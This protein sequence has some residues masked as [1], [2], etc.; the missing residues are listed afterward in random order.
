MLESYYPVVGGM[1]AQGRTL[2]LALKKQ[3]V[4]PFIITRKTGAELKCDEEVDGIPVHRC[5][6]SGAGSRNRWFF[7]FT[8][9]PALIRFRHR[10]D[11][12][13]VSGFRVL[14]IS[15]VLIGKLFG[16][17]TVLKAECMGE[18]NGAFFTGGL[19]LLRLKQGFLGMRLFLAIRNRWLK[20]GDAFVSMY[21]EMTEEFLACGVKASAIYTI[22]NAVDPVGFAPPSAETKQALFLELGL[23]GA[24]RYMVYT[25]RL[26]SYKGVM[27]LLRVWDAIRKN[28][29]DVVLLM[30]GAGGVDV[31]NCEEEA[32]Q[33]AA[34]HE[35]G[36]QVVFTGAVR[37]VDAWLK[38]C[39]LFILPTEN[40][41]FP[42]CIL[43]AMSTALAIIAT[44]TGALKDVIRDGE[45]GRIIPVGCDE[46][47]R[48]AMDELL[49]NAGERRRLGEAAR[50][51][52]LAHYTPDAV[53]SRYMELF[54]AVGK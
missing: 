7:L 2:A 32:R 33:Y 40:D 34:A 20:L 35:M 17:T 36:E 53:V 39:D 46:S 22:P 47:L 1:E 14:G 25:G 16:K 50:K 13:L 31:F 12:L 26:V 18:M 43:E 52:V 6:P 11:V 54:R 44:P 24:R 37:N 48:A 29:P 9:I 5:G 42:V 51:D 49:N 27:R 4:Q 38:A 8:S 28:H 19:N 30:I 3:G 10:Y 23:S 15:A 41:A 21:S 45:T